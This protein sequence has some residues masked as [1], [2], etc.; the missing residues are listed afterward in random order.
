MKTKIISY[1]PIIILLLL[2]MLFSNAL[3]SGKSPDIIDSVLVGKP[4]PEIS[5]PSVAGYEQ[6][7]P[8]YFKGKNITLVNFF[9]SW[10]APC[11]L[12][13][14]DLIK[15]KEKNVHI[16]GIIYNDDEKIALEFLEKNGN[17]YQNIA[18]DIEGNQAFEWGVY[19]IPETFFVDDMGII[20]YRH[21][22]PLTLDIYYQILNNIKKRSK[23]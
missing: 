23:E 13:H 12:E 17:P 9:A 4:V 22:G 21:T 8:E 20:Q 10:C 18:K 3:L 19:G 6:I 16:V 7:S 1:I 5:F 14:P 2:V 11:K 15:L